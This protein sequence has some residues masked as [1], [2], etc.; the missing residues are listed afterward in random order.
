MFV[1][2]DIYYESF[3]GDFVTIMMSTYNSN[4]IVT[5]YGSGNWTDTEKWTGPIGNDGFWSL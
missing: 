2:I 5:L 3:L 4:D 1:E